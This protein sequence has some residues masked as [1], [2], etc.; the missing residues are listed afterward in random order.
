MLD[1]TI[2]TDWVKKMYSEA[3]EII[4]LW[5][6]RDMISGKKMLLSMLMKIKR[7]GKNIKNEEKK[8]KEKYQEWQW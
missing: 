4:F 1:R 3:N 7:R 8:K 6:W 2:E 5:R